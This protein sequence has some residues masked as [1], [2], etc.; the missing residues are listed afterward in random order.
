MQAA[1]CRPLLWRQVAPGT[2]ALTHVTT[3]YLGRR[4]EPADEAV[5]V[6][7][8]LHPAVVPGEGVVSLLVAF[9]G[10]QHGGDPLPP[11]DAQLVVQILL[12]LSHG[13]ER[14]RARHVEHH[15]G[16]EGVTVVDTGHVPKTL[17]TCRVREGERG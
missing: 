12:P 11:G 16:A 3:R 4:L 7:E 14:A 17:L 1:G 15:E 9:V 13:L 8:L 2:R 6:A 10:E 5:L